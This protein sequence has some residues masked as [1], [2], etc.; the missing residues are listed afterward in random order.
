MAIEAWFMD[1]TSGEDQRLPRHCNPKEFV[2][3]DYLAELGVLHWRLNPANYENDE[4]LKKIREERGYNYMDLLDICP[5]KVADFKEKLKNFYTEHIH[6]D[7]EIRY[8]L[9]GSAY[10]DVRDKDDRWIRIWIKAGDLI[11]L[12]AGIYHRFTLDTGDYVKLMRL[13][14]G[15]PVWTA[16]NRPQEDHPARKEYIKSMVTEKGGVALEAY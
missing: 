1:E 14:V 16:Y 12:P 10:F 8:C 9:E 11:I 5:E 4:E 2:S 3:L 6:A 15:E 7:E 13:F